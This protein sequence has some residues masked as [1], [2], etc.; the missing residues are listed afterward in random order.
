VGLHVF[1]YRVLGTKGRE[2][3]HC[4]L[5]RAPIEFVLREPCEGAGEYLHGPWTLEAGFVDRGDETS[6]VEAAF[7]TKFP[8]PRTVM[9]RVR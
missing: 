3:F 1:T 9:P 6:D 7:A 4:R 5:E 8:L 2:L